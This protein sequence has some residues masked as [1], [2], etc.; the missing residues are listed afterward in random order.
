M[1]ARWM[2]KESL[3]LS[4]SAAAAVTVQE[5]AFPEVI[6]EWPWML[7][8]SGRSVRWQVPAVGGLMVQIVLVDSGHFDIQRV[9]VFRDRS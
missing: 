5:V 9:W 3:R 2:R 4:N 8:Q 6:V 1:S 7:K